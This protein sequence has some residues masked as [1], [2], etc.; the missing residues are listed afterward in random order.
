MALEVTGLGGAENKVQP[1]APLPSAF[2]EKTL[3]WTTR[4]AKEEASAAH[5]SLTA[6][7]A[8]RAVRHGPCF[9]PQ[10]SGPASPTGHSESLFVSVPCP[11]EAVTATTTDDF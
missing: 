3:M 4:L 6:G 10:G 7:P 11:A 2:W 8:G 5:S 9:S 1:P